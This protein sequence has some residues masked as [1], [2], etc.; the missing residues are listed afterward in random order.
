MPATNNAID[1]GRSDVAWKDGYFSGNVYAQ[2]TYN[3][4]NA[5]DISNNTLTEAQFAIVTFYKFILVESNPVLLVDP[6]S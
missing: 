5:S 3:V 6:V 4:I 1:L 2:N